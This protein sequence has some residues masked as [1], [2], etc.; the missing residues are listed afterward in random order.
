MRRIDF[1]FHDTGGGRYGLGS[2]RIADFDGYCEI[3]LGSCHLF[4]AASIQ[5]SQAILTVVKDERKVRCQPYHNY[6]Q[7]VSS[8][9]TRGVKLSVHMQPLGA[10]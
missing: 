1:E 3:L 9:G 6:V 8:R 4:G 10:T 5:A 2:R 7:S